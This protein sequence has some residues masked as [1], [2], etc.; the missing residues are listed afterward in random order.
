VRSAAPV[1]VVLAAFAATAAARAP[2]ASCPDDPALGSLRFVRAGH[3]HVV[4]LA[5]CVDVVAGRAPASRAQ[6][7][8]V[9]PDGRFSAT[10][11]ATGRGQTARQTIW[12]TNLG[13]HRSHPVAS[14][15]QY[16]KTIGP[17]DTAGPL[18]LFGFSPDD[19]WI[20][21]TVDPGSSASIAADGTVLRVVAARGGPVHKLGIALDYV[22]YHAWCGDRL[23]FTAGFDRVATNHKSLLVASPPS[24]RP[25]SLW[26]DPRESFGSVTCAPDE[27]SVAVEA[28]HTSEDAGFFAPRWQ[29]WRVG[30]DGSRRILD[31]PPPGTADESP[32]WSP[33]GRWLLFVRERMGFGAVM[34]LHARSL[35]GPVANL[36]FSLGYYGHHDWPVRWTA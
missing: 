34:L 9:S 5:I 4:S 19:K 6:T 21:F 24:W 3:V 2:V 31:V 8:I 25:R 14:E 20:L 29:L 35:Y 36:G 30:L 18:W 33:G 12:V 32:Q 1:L 16:Y 27:R 15:T 17:G 28:Q 13:I 10:I 22:D 7:P 26:P 23:V 11:R